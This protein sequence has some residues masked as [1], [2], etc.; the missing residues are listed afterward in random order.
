MSDDEIV[1][2]S[3]KR[4]FGGP[5]P[6]EWPMIEPTGETRIAIVGDLPSKDEDWYGKLFIGETGKLLESGLGKVGLVRSQCLLCN[7]SWVRPASG[8]FEDLNW[9]DNEIQCGLAHLEE[10]LEKFDPTIV[11]CLGNEALHVMKRGNVDPWGFAKLSIHH[12]RGTLFESTFRPGQKCLATFHPKTILRDFSEQMYFQFDMEKLKAESKTRELVLPKR[13]VVVLR[14]REEVA[15]KLKEIHANWTYCSLDIEGW[16]NNITAVSFSQSADK[17]YVVPFAH[18]DGS[19][20]WSEED[21]YVAWEH[22]R[23]V[24][25]D[26]RIHMIAQNGSYDFHALAFGL[27]ICVQGYTEDTLLGWWEL[28]PEM[29]KG[30]STQA[31]ILTNEPYYK[32]EKSKGSLKFAD[33]EAFWEYN[34]VDAAVTYECWEKQQARMTE[35]QK[36]HYRFNM[37]L[38]AGPVLY[39]M[40]RGILFDVGRAKAEQNRANDEIA[41]LQR[42]I[43]VESGITFNCETKKN[44]FEDVLEIV[45]KNFCS[46]KMKKKATVTLER[47]QPM[48]HNGKR[49][50]RG[51]KL[52][53]EH[54]EVAEILSGVL[55][56]KLEGLRYLPM[57]VTKEKLVDAEPAR[58]SEC[59]EFIL[60]SKREDWI[61]VKKLIAEIRKD[62]VSEALLGK[63]SQAL[64][65]AVNVG[66]TQQDGDAQTFLY[67]VCELPRVLVNDRGQFSFEEEKDRVRRVAGEGTTNYPGKKVVSSMQAL[68]KLYAKT[69]DVRALWCLQ[70]RRLRK[71]SSDLNVKLDEDQR[72]RASISLVKETGRMAESKT[73]TGTGM[74][75]Q[76][77]NK[78]LRRVCVADPGRSLYQFDLEGADNWTVA[79]ECA[80]LGDATMLHDLEAGLKPAKILSLIVHLGPEKVQGMTRDEIKRSLKELAGEMPKWLY[81][82]CKAAVHGC[83]TGDHEVLTPG[84]W[85]RLDEYQIGTPIM[86]YDLH[87]RFS[88]FEV[89]EDV[90]QGEHK[91]KMY[92]LRGNSLSQIVTPCHTLPYTTN[93]NAKHKTAEELHGF[94]GASLPMS[95]CYTGGK[96]KEHVQL[97]AAFQAD[98]TISHKQVVWHFKKQRKILRIQ[99]LLRE[100][101]IPYRITLNK[102]GTTTIA[103]KG[104]VAQTW[105]PYKQAGAY[106]LTWNVQSLELF[107]T[108]HAHWDG[109]RTDVNSFEVSAVNREHLDW[110]A[111]VSKLVMRSYTWNDVR[112]SGYGSTVHSIKF[113]SRSYAD[114]DSLYE[115]SE[116]A[117]RDH[118][119]YC[120]VTSTGFFMVRHNGKISITGNSSY[121]MGWKVMTETVLKHSLHTLPLELASASPLTLKKKDVEALQKAFFSRW[122]GVKKWQNHVSDALLNQ[123]W[124]DTGVGHRR[125]FQGRKAEWRQGVKQANNSTLKEALS[126]MPQ[127]FTT[128]FTKLALFNLWFDEENV[129]EDGEMRLEPI[130]CVHDSLLAQARDE[131]EAWAKV[132]IKKYF[133]NKV[134][135]AGQLIEIPAEG[136]IGSD[137]GM[138]DEVL[139]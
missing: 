64:G 87:T 32:P 5:L 42:L 107:L 13:D 3:G 2:S 57:P 133:K 108:E 18:N 131:D 119:V 78:D 11:L 58:L 128:Y 43:D 113:N 95:S 1:P 99:E 88:S 19:N 76:A 50:V 130:L 120:P 77:L 127:F 94:K 100:A 67:T 66:S 35:Q 44:D 16:M 102:D 4:K 97:I 84:G 139:I 134:E 112:T 28:Y 33:D 55:D 70:I 115:F 38:Q 20:Y 8:L 110:L 86:I 48:K 135:I 118:K 136:T 73:P 31:S 129:R 96:E 122:E 117:K 79:A 109:H 111:T 72:A 69:E 17:A 90:Y 39:M 47:W 123:G 27:G 101:N 21:E 10:D 36:K 40:L 61:E 29:K 137:W 91:G 85:V 114:L 121:G 104:D 25:E 81:P 89:P 74:N 92:R 53:L 24:V 98:G 12:W 125:L 65:V 23:Y 60:K 105:H 30:L 80:R 103:T 49:W 106:L 132:A 116:S 14:T 6:N 82:A 63:L 59:E 45:K 46:K 68:A 56:E 51:G 26:E 124:L 71:I 54:P 75:R 7:V 138:E 15:E 83:V 9:E 22:I 52:T 62:G 41:K 126:S 93:G 37:D 34:G